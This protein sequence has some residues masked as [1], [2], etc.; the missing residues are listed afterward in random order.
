M[1]K[2][3]PFPSS[4]ATHPIIFHSKLST[5][6]KTAL[7]ANFGKINFVKETAKLNSFS[8]S[9]SLYYLPF[10]QET[11]LIELFLIIELY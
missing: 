11:H 9:F 10:Y 1:N 4:T 2:V 7:V 5:T 3:D 6:D 8:F